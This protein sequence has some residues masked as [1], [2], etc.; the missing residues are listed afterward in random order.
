MKRRN[1]LQTLS[2]AVPG[3]VVAPA[4][5]AS[6]TKHHQKISK[7]SKEPTVFS[8]DDGRHASGLYQFAPP[9]EA[10]DLTA[11]RV[12]FAGSNGLLA[13]DGDLTFSTDTLTATKIGAFTA[14]GAIDF[15]S[16]NM[17]NVDI[18]SGTIN[19]ITDLAVAD[20][21]TGVSTLTSN[22]VLVG[23]GTGAITSSSNLSFDDT[24]LTIA[25][26]GKMEFNDTGT[27]INSSANSY[28][29]MRPPG[30]TPSGKGDNPS[31]SVV[32]FFC[33]FAR[34]AKVNNK[35][36]ASLYSFFHSAI[37]SA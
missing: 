19:G 5:A 24:D 25:S 6:A 21:G 26:T 36:S 20:G 3:A 10:S 17:T 8:Y 31:I 34:L 1:F 37:F 16:Q 7:Q 12:T 33:S 9:L 28:L 35:A 4:A 32:F 27:Y 18:N 11:G 29:S 23:N 2:L 30:S 14:A 22:G 15:D 13:D